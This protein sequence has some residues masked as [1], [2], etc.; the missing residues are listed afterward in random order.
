MLLA[1]RRVLTMAVLTLPVSSVIS[2]DLG[3]HYAE[4]LGYAFWG[5]RKGGDEGKKTGN[6][7]ALVRR[8]KKKKALLE[9]SK[10]SS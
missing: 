10:N 5:L 4:G 8:T 9:T 3:E 2:D 7:T 1:L 6:K